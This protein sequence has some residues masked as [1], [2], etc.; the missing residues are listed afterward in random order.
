[1]IKIKGISLGADPELFVENTKGEIV[2]AEG[3]IGGTK[4]EPKYLTTK[5]AGH[6]IQEDN[7]MVEFNI[8]P[9]YTE[10]E[11]VANLNIV[12][13]HLNTLLALQDGC[14]LNYSASAELNPKYLLTPQAKMFGCEP[15]FNVHLKE[16]NTSPDPNTNLRTAGGHIHI[17]YSNPD[18]EVSEFIVYAMDIMLGLASVDLDQDDRRKEMYGLAGCFRFKSY[19]VEYRSLSNFWLISEE[20][21]R[22]AYQKTH[23]AIDLVNSGLVPELIEKYGT[24]I[25]AA[26]DTNDK[27]LAK[28]TIAKIN[29]ILTKKLINVCVE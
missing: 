3:M 10:N 24:D 1:M 25:K 18:T 8:P 17:G 23:D 21:K 19:G 26:I 20:L 15:D 22:W 11:F 14:K 28:E 12:E 9:C 2:S 4:E 7:I 16:P 6:A 29:K 5:K 27:P 13:E